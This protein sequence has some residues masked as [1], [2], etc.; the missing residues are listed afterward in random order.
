VASQLLQRDT[1]VRWCCLGA[2][3]EASLPVEY[4]NEILLLY[5]LLVIQQRPIDHQETT[6]HLDF[7]GPEMGTDQRPPVTLSYRGDTSTTTL[8]IQWLYNGTFHDY[9]QQQQRETPETTN[10]LLDYD[11]FILLNPGLGHDHLRKDWRPTLDLLLCLPR[12]KNHQETIR[13]KTKGRI[14]LMAHSKQDAD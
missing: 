7:I 1:V 2:R 3:A 8:M 12:T 13:P 9:H 5:H 6:I 11:A 4:W 10:K 14:L